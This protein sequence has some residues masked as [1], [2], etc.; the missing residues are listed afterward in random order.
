MLVSMS[1]KLEP[2]E[3]RGAVAARPVAYLLLP[4]VTR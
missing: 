1:I 4:T 3:L 2:S